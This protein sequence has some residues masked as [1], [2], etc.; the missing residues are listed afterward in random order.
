[1][2]SGFCN[3]IAGVLLLVL[4]SACAQKTDSPVLLANS[5]T[6]QDEEAVAL[7][8]KQCISCHA[9]DLGGRVGPNLQKVGSKL[10]KED[11][12]KVIHDGAKG[13][14]G[15]KDKL[16]SEGIEAIARWLSKYN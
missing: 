13:M 8:K 5:T 1:M 2:M 16:S 9:N 15:Y 14:P 7:Y 12:Y 3:F 11:I 10:A 4:L 6:P